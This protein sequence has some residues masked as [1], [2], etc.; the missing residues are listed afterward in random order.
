[1]AEA[2]LQDMKSNPPFYPGSNIPIDRPQPCLI[3]SKSTSMP[4]RVKVL[5]AI[6]A[7]LRPSAS[8]CETI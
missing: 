7:E 1:M 3:N 8:I 6:L 4:A 2:Y 5:N